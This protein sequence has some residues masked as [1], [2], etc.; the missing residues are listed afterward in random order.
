MTYVPLK[1]IPIRERA[2][3]LFLEHGQIDVADQAFVLID[4]AGRTHIPVGGLACLMLEPG[5]RISHAA[6]VLAAKVNCLLVWTGE[7]GVRLYASGQPG[8]ASAR[9]LLYQA[10]IALD[11]TA[12]LNVVRAMY[13]QR[14]GEAAPDRRSIDQLRGLEG[15]RVRETYRRLAAEHGVTWVARRYDPGNYRASDVPNQCISAATA[16]L[17]GLTEAA[18]LAAGYAPQI[19]FLHSGRAQSFVYDIADLFKF[20][21][22]VPEA[23]R[24]AAQ[25]SAAP[26]R[27]TDAPT[28]P[29]GSASAESEAPNKRAKT[30]SLE[31]AV[32]LACRDAFRKTRL[33]D[34]LI[35]SIHA[36]LAAS[37]IDI[38]ADAPEGVPPVLPHADDGKDREAA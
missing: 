26:G 10:R 36:V 14:F 35:P 31:R 34:R 1:P 16:C 30:Q 12:R 5:T 25:W 8:G 3:I 18:I 24:I 20:E 23:F 32:R 28:L 37:G 7:A 15:V 27:R 33:L 13:A 22:V 21:T 17:Y 11:D 29:A 38:P 6:V 4:D 9:H 19:G 2:S